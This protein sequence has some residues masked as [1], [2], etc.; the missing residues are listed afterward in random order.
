MTTH[1]ARRDI[2]AVVNLKGGTSKTTTAVYLAHAL[3]ERGRRVLLVDADPQGSALA[4][5]EDA[6]EPFP[7]P[8]IGLPTRELHRQLMDAVSPDIDAIVID[9][10]PL[11][12]KSGIVVSAL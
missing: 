8:V 1:R 5:N 12:H 6:P 11:D 2:L 3:Y 9:T 4:W 10:P 7:F